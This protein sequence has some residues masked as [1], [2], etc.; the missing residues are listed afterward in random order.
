MKRYRLWA[1]G[2]L[3]AASAALAEDVVTLQDG[4]IRRGRVIDPGRNAIEV[5]SPLGTIRVLKR[6]VARIEFGLGEERKEERTLDR[7]LTK[8]GREIAGEVR[9]SPDG[10]SVIVKIPGGEVSFPRDEVVRIIGR[11]GKDEEGSVASSAGLRER[12]PKW[13]ADLAGSGG[14]EAER[15]LRESG[16]LAAEALAAAQES[17]TG[18]AAE[19]VRRLLASLDLRRTVGDTLDKRMPNIYEVLEGADAEKKVTLLKAS[20]LAA[21]EEAVAL[22]GFVL[23]DPAES[24]EVR[25]FATEFLRRLNRNKE[26][27]D[28][29]AGSSG[30]AQFAVAL[31]LGENGIYVGI[32]TLIEALEVEDAE[33]QK[34]AIERLR[35]WTGADFGFVPGDPDE[36]KRATALAAWRVWWEGNRA[37]VEHEASLHIH[38]PA[39]DSP[40]RIRAIELWT[41]A[42]RE[43]SRGNYDAAEVGLRRSVFADP[44][45]VGASLSLGIF[46]ARVRDQ[47]VEAGTIL[48]KV[49]E[50]RFVSMGADCQMF[51]FFHL[52]EL[53]AKGGRFAE[54]RRFFGKALVAKPEFIEARLALARLLHS[55][56]IGTANLKPEDRLKGIDAALAEY[57]KAIASID[58]YSKSL[59]LLRVDDIPVGEQIP[60]VRRDHNQSLLALRKHLRGEKAAALCSMARATIAKRDDEGARTLVLEAIRETEEYVPARLILARLLA[61]SGDAEGAA[62]EYREVLRRDPENPEAKEGLA[63]AGA[64][65]G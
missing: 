34:I 15:R 44:T 26:L 58:A 29:Y 42:N 1:A 53:H 39:D 14:E 2:V 60:F 17:A 12:I 62:R 52:G 13:I 64:A 50:R 24:A 45:F 41:E 6:D 57:R 3:A 8:D 16:I 38:P 22:L 61:K 9:F 11:G 32:P 33:V 31:A 47:P 36:K 65:G 59:V 35:A 40:E 21:P 48:R 4:E 5:I 10:K 43:W 20:F 55:E 7:V 63:R 27:I 19:R 37:A 46:L 25:S 28:V 54:A 51:A 56:A 30:R 18:V 23:K 49:A